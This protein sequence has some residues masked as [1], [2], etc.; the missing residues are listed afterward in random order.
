MHKLKKLYENYKVETDVN[1]LAKGN[2]FYSQLIA[3][4]KKDILNDKASILNFEDNKYK[5]YFSLHSSNFSKEF[6]DLNILI[7]VT[8]SIS[9]DFLGFFSMQ[10]KIPQ[11]ILNS[12][13]FLYN[14]AREELDVRGLLNFLESPQ[15][16]DI[17]LHEFIHYLYYTG[18]IKGIVSSLSNLNSPANSMGRFEVTK[19]YI[20]FLKEKGFDKDFLKILENRFLGRKYN[21]YGEFIHPFF[22]DAIKEFNLKEKVTILLP[23]IKK[24]LAL[25]PYMDFQYFNSKTEFE[26]YFYELINNFENFDNVK[27]YSSFEEF[28]K[29]LENFHFDASGFAENMDKISYKKLIDRLKQYYDKKT[30]KEFK[31]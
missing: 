7:E 23:N 10:N 24:F 2:L 16:R 3:A 25:R 26:S 21:S 15:T 1:L 8:P 6:K 12:G 9:S 29:T 5:H 19:R 30:F 13:K 28:L 27:N 17:F 4:I 31:K 11:I 20:S 18:K 22:V 14:A